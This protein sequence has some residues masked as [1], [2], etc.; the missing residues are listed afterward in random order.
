MGDLDQKPRSPSAPRASWFAPV[1]AV[2]LLGALA[3]YMTV[4]RFSAVSL[5]PASGMAN[6]MSAAER[7][8]TRYA[9]T[10]PLAT[11][12]EAPEALAVGPDGRVYV[13]G[14]RMVRVWRGGSPELEYTV[15]EQPHC[16]AVAP[17]GTVYVGF[18][19]YVGVYDARGKLVTNW[20]A[21]GVH[22]YLT[23]IAT[24]GDS[25]WVAD[26]GNRVV[27]HYDRQGNLLGRLGKPD[28]AHPARELVVP[29]P[30]LGMVLGADG[31]LRVANPGRHEVEVYGTDGVW[32]SA[33]G[34]ASDALDGFCG[35]CNP[36]NLALLPDG[37]VVTAEKG[38]PRVKVYLPDGRLE[39]VVAGEQ[40]FRPETA[41]LSLATDAQGRIYVLDPSRRTVR[42]FV[43]L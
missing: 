35:C 13:G 32:Q 31:L 28:P 25:V 18:R 34:K 38:Q 40:A 39:S 7:A 19:D 15:A 4:E 1:L 21:Q 11:G 26:A 3:A 30:Y 42:V 41:G 8:W 22:A 27:L 29:S 2:V 24:D 10:T 37:R 36:T 14:D 6:S 23:A 12:M 9:E 5:P 33:W 16:L 17:D 20:A 43:H